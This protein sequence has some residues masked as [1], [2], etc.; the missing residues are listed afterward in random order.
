[1][2]IRKTPK[3]AKTKKSK[4]SKEEEGVVYAT[5]G[6]TLEKALEES[7]VLSTGTAP[8]GAG[9]APYLDPIDVTYKILKFGK[10]LTGIPL[11][12]YQEVI[13]FRIIYSVITFE[14]SVLTV[15]LSRQS[16]KSEVMAFVI[17][18]LAVILPALAKI[19]PELEQ[20]QSGFKIGLFAPQSDQVFTTYNRAMLRISSENARLVM[21]DPEINTELASEARLVL[22][23]GSFLKGQVA[24]KQS[25]IESKTYDLVI[26]EEAQDLDDY[27][28]QKSIEPMVS[29][30]GGTI[31]KVGTTGTTKNHYWYE[32]QNNRNLDRK[33]KD[34][35]LYNHWEFDYKKVIQHRREQFAIDHKGF[36][37]HYE[38]DVERKIQRWGKDSQAFKLGYALEWDLESGMLITDKEWEKI[39]NRKKGFAKLSEDDFIVAGLDI[40]KDIASTVLT[41]AKVEEMDDGRRKKE[42]VGW[43][44]LGGL[45][46]EVQHHVLV[47]TLADYNVKVL[48]ADYT[49]VGKAV[50]DRLIYAC[51]EYVEIVPY[52]FS[53]QSKS[54][55]WYHFLNTIQ[56]RL[57]VVPAGAKVK[58][59]VEFM[60]FEEQMKNCTKT[61]DGPYMVCEKSEGYFDDYVDSA[62]LCCLAGDHNG[63]DM[64]EVEED[65]FNPLLGSI[66][67]ARLT[68]ESMSYL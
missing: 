33:V 6:A 56:S 1:M 65:D 19:F 51:G 10:V 16:G 62:A 61:F 58:G 38:K 5:T 25:K 54:E 26:L 14:G 60:H 7:E 28:V 27:L 12:R 68:R 2:P 50:C 37:L 18:T 63:A 42:I 43:V 31:V 29:H 32:I 40:A 34:E 30:T 44:E 59:T 49:G 3:T 47:Q 13:A 67:E 64:Y 17:N 22:T 46:Y 24:S 4:R 23:N 21:E 52:P 57:L 9:G 36:H 48:Y 53:R 35:R 66:A 15:L 39:V 11:Y 41:L 8:K 55:M 20:F 45:D